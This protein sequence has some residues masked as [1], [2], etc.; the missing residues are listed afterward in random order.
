[1]DIHVLNREMAG[2]YVPDKP[3]ILIGILNS[4]PPENV[5]VNV[6]PSNFRLAYLTYVVDDIDEKFEDYILISRDTASRIVDD[7]LRYRDRIEG[8]AVHC[9]AGLSRS[10]AVAVALNECFSLGHE[11]REFFSEYY[12]VNYAVYLAIHSAWRERKKAGNR[13]SW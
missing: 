12:T 2:K 13:E 9:L 11:Q 1:M 5:P 3:E 8:F 10:P 7:F 4:K 6:V